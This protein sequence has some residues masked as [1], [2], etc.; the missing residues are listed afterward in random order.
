MQDNILLKDEPTGDRIPKIIHQTYFS[1]ELPPEFARNVEFLKSTNPGWDYRL[2]DDA[3]IHKFLS[4]NYDP[5]IL[6]LYSRIN[7]KYGAARADFF[8]YLLLYKVGGVYLDIKSS[9]LKP[10]DDILLPSDKYILAGWCN[11]AGEKYEGFGKWR[12]LSAMPNGELQ[13]WHIICC[14]GHPFLKAVI[15]NVIANITNYRA[16]RHGVGGHAVLNTTGPIAYSKAIYPIMA[17]HP[18]RYVRKDVDLYLQYSAIG[19]KSHR[20]VI[21]RPHY[22]LVSEPVVLQPGTIGTMNAGYARMLARV[23]GCKNDAKTRL[24]RLLGR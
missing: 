8:R 22:K 17:Q 2:Y 23:K 14:A 9:I 13:Q 10:I 7:P 4:E 1:H 12:E 15:Q 3:D 18:H 11:E 19:D 5:E 20:D 6:E 16:W 21:A 24:K